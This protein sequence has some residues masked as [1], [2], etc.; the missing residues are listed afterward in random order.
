MDCSLPGFFVHI[1]GVFQARILEW[2]AIPN[3][4]LE[5]RPPA[6]H[7]DSL[8]GEPPERPNLLLIFVSFIVTYVM[9]TYLEHPPAHPKTCFQTQSSFSLME[10][11][12]SGRY[13]IGNGP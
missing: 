10:P 2:V 7:A 8:P 11:V 1:H 6:L 4:K 3:S 9:L 5:L 12:N 13:N